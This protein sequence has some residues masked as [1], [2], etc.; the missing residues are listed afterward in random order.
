MFNW[1]YIALTLLLAC[2]CGCA[3]V[4]TEKL[5][6]GLSREEVRQLLGKPTATHFNKLQNNDIEVWDYKKS[7]LDSLMLIVGTE[8]GGAPITKIARLWFL[9]GQLKLWQSAEYR[10]GEREALTQ[11]PDFE[12]PSAPD[13]I[14]EIRE[15]K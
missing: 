7:R 4:K 6:K 3:T 9:N 12:S 5:R 13:V 2:F 15:K 11:P 1:R 8:G 14:L 10:K